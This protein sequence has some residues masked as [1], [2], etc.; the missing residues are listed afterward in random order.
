MSNL[1]APAFALAV[2]IAF[3]GSLM[4][5]AM[6]AEPFPRDSHTSQVTLRHALQGGFDIE[7]RREATPEQKIVR[8]LGEEL[9]TVE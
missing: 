7:D 6:A 3:A 8:V 2:S 1:H 5:K 9:Y 4:G